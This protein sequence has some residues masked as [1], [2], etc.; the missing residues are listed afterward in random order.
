MAEVSTQPVAVREEKLKVLKSL[1]PIQGGDTAQFTVRG[2]YRAGAIGGQ[3]V[4]G[5]GEEQ[6]AGGGSDTET[7]VAIKTGIDN[8]RWSGVPFY[9]RTGKRL[10]ERCSEIAIEFTRPPHLLYPRDAGAIEPNRL[11]IRVQPDEAVRLQLLNKEPGP[12]EL[13]LRQT[14]LNLSFAETFGTHIPDA[15][16]RLL[17]DVIRGRPTLFMS[18]AELEEAWRWTDRI[19]D[20]W[21]EYPHPVR[22]YTAGGWGPAAALA[23]IE[24]DG[25][26]WRDELT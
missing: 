18:R 12:G 9:L 8:W 24:R 11:I 3:P 13:K 26:S 15:Y 7:F 4:P 21:R 16:E 25:R 19:I 6:D 1:K 17:L 20:G 23:L 2:Q 22:P 5:Y 10:A 14:A